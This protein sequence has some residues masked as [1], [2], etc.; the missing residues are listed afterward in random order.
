MIVWNVEARWFADDV[1][2]ED[3]FFGQ[4]EPEAPGATAPPS[5]STPSGWKSSEAELMQ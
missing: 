4:P 2:S 5:G 3:A 1:E